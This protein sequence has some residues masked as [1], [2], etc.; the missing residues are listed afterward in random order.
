M[1]D[2]RFFKNSG[3]FTLEEIYKFIGKELLDS[4]ISNNYLVV[5]IATLGHAN[6]GNI[7]FYS[8]GNFTDLCKGPHIENTSKIK[9][10]KLLNIAGAYW[11]GDE[12]NKMLQRIYGTV[13][14]SK[15]AL[16][17]H[18][19]NLEEAKRRDHRKIGK[20]MQLFA[21]DGDIGPGLPL[22]LPNGTV[23][24]EELEVLAKDTE[25]KAGYTQVRTPHLTKGTICLLYT[26]PSPRD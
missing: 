25:K 15:E 17:K 8:Q 3:P 5:D 11:R 18:L 23:M 9:A 24:I 14:S 21:F 2:P 7:T 12:N 26:S 20:E 6:D 19:E 22:W 16:K 13:F 4:K 10:I 1:S